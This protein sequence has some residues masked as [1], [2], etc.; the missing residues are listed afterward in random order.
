M[1]S[2]SIT[3]PPPEAVDVPAAHAASESGVGMTRTAFQPC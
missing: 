2:G 3:S 1:A